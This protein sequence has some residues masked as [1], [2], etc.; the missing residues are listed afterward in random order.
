[1]M[2]LLFSAAAAF[3]LAGDLH[4]LAVF[5]AAAVATAAR[6]P[7]TSHYVPEADSRYDRA[8]PRL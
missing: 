4:I 3:I 8:I 7:Y 5:F 1:M 2:S 6:S